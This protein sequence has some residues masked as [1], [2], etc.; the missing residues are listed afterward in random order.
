M[1]LQAGLHFNNNNRK[2]FSFPGGPCR[3]ILPGGDSR[4]RVLDGFIL[5]NDVMF[6]LYQG[7]PLLLEGLLFSDDGIFVCC[8]KIILCFQHKHSSMEIR[9]GFK[10]DQIRVEG[11]NLKILFKLI[12]VQRFLFVFTFY[13][14]IDYLICSFKF[15]MFF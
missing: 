3:V 2:H 5:P 6:L 15:L 1:R 14:I 12:S 4:Y 9:S 8:L 13:I 7:K 10:R 11:H